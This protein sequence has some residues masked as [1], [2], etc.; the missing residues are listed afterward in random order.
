MCVYISGIMHVHIFV[1]NVV[2]RSFETAEDV[3]VLRRDALGYAGL[4]A[5]Q[6]IPAV[7]AATLQQPGWAQAVFFIGLSTSL[8][9]QSLGG[10]A[11]V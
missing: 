7:C 5:I 1:L 11:C 6:T 10:R 8:A 2:P 9:R 3:Q 4:C